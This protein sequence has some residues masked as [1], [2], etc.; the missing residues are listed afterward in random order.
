MENR[1]SSAAKKE[2]EMSYFKKGFRMLTKIFIV[3]VVIYM[4]SDQLQGFY[5]E[6]I[7][8]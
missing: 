8:S 7:G 3:L 1:F 2:R 5:D 6:Q 4:V